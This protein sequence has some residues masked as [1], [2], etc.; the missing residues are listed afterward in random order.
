MIND[1][2]CFDE[3]LLVARFQMIVSFAMYVLFVWQVV[4]VEA[5]L[6]TEAVM[7]LLMVVV[8]VVEDTV[9]DMAL[10]VDMVS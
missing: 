1:D 5:D 9:V 7:G 2:I 3:H 6:V 10:R 8:E 4:V